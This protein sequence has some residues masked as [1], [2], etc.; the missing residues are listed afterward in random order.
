MTV[1]PSSRLLKP[2]YAVA[3]LAIAVAYGY[4][5]NRTERMDWLIIPPALLLIW[6]LVK[7]F[8]LRFTTLTIA[9]RKLRFETG[10]LQ[11]TS[12]TMEL[13]KVQ[14]VRVDQS[15]AQRLLGIGDLSIE[16][17]GE[18][19]GLVMKNIDQPQVVADFI[20]ESAHKP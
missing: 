7:H 5:N 3:F 15:L 4:N 6:V 10:M 12:R 2:V 9:N 1:R 19:S 8:R 18:A 14:D 17:A 16:T 11:K 13:A 20:L